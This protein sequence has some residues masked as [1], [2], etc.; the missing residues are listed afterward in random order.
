MQL[1]ATK[2]I[3]VDGALR[4]AGEVFEGSRRWKHTEPVCGEAKK[5]TAT[6]KPKD[7]DRKAAMAELTAA[8]VKFK[9]NSS[10]DELKELLEQTRKEFAPASSGAPSKEGGTG[11][12]DV[13]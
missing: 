4:H 13:I 5:E 11:D 12:Q 7:F 2:P 9:G 10:N 8:G 3:F 6:Q 1:R